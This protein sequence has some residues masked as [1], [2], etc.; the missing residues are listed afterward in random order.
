MWIL[1]GQPMKIENLE[2]QILARLEQNA[3]APRKEIAFSLGISEASLSKRVSSLSAEQYISKF[4]IDVD[5][6]K[7]GFPVTSITF[8]K[9]QNPSN[10]LEA[11]LSDLVKLPYAVEVATISGEWDV[12]VRWV[13][14][15]NGEMMPRLRA[16]LPKYNMRIETFIFA[17]IIRRQS[18]LSTMDF[19]ADGSA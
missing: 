9:L 6:A 2:L 3:T 16:I 1:A 18:R 10:D 19:G 11:L 4:T 12:M 17:E 5:Y 8:F 7:I 13:C 14:R 15:D